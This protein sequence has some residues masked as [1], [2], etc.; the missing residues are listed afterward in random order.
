MNLNRFEDEV[1]WIKGK[2]SRNERI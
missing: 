2:I 1:V